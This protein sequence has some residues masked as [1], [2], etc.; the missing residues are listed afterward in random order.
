MNYLLDFTIL[1]ELMSSTPNKTL[2]KWKQGVSPER[3]FISVIS[4]GELQNQIYN[5]EKNTH[6]QVK[7]QNLIDLFGK[8]VLPINLLI[9]ENWGLLYNPKGPEVEKTTG[10][11]AATS[12]AYKLTVVTQN[13]R[14]YATFQVPTLNPIN[15]W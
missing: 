12:Y 1:N 4:I 7:L 2:L 5:D 6:Q 11:I 3:L 13:P 14:R 15:L 8:R 9:A 10:L